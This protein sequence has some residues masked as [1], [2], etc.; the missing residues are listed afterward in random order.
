MTTIGLAGGYASCHRGREPER[1]PRGKPA[2]GGQGAVGKWMGLAG[3]GLSPTL[4]LVVHILGAI[5]PC[6]AC[7]TGLWMDTELPWRRDIG[8]LGARPQHTVPSQPWDWGLREPSSGKT[9]DISCGSG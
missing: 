1:E 3:V 9:E 2:A 4:R 5:P 8:P 6:R 7:Q